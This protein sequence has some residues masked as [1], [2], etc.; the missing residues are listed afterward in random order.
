M[1]VPASEMTVRY[2]VGFGNYVAFFGSWLK[3][4]LFDRTSHR[5]FL[6]YSLVAAALLA[7]SM[8]QHATGF[9]TS[10]LGWIFVVVS[11]VITA[12]LCAAI[13]VFIL[14]PL[15]LFIWHTGR[16]LFNPKVEQ[17]VSLSSAGITKT[18]ADNETTTEW[19]AVTAF[20]ET[21]KTVLL[22]TGRNAAMIIP[23]SAFS[24]PGDAD[25]FTAAARHHWE[26]AHSIF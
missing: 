3:R 14:G 12:L 2:K 19:R 5:R 16:Y 26:D 9:I 17:A 1:S 21:R 8:W 15:L 25:R 11:I 24:S 4:S 10:S 22:F 7:F 6:I 23:K 18:S 13:L 20:V